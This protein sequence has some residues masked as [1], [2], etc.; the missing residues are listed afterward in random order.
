MACG[1]D[2]FPRCSN[3]RN[4]MPGEG[5]LTCPNARPVIKRP[6]RAGLQ[7][8]TC[9][10]RVKWILIPPHCCKACKQGRQA[11]PWPESHQQHFALGHCS[12]GRL[13]VARPPSSLSPENDVPEYAKDTIFLRPCSKRTI[14]KTKTMG[15]TQFGGKS[16]GVY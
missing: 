14:R 12:W 1:V 15:A 4:N 3:S 13:F 8:R 11:Q 10:A 5:P 6:S 16:S 9:F 2:T 7:T